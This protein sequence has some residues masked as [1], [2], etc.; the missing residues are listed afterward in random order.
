MNVKELIMGQPPEAIA[1]ILL[2]KLCAKPD[3]RERVLKRLLK[4]IEDLHQI[5]PV[6][7]GHLILGIV[8][9]DEDGDF[10]NPCLY[11]KEE[12]EPGY[13]ADSELAGLE[14]IEGL[15]EEEIEWLA[16]IRDFPASYA[17]EFSPW[18]EILGY[19]IDACN[20][21][22]VGKAELCAAVIWEMTF[23]GFD[24]ERVEEERQKLYEATREAEEISKL[25]KEEREKHYVS[26]EELFS[27]FGLPER[28]EEEKQEAHRNL[29]REVLTNNLRTYRALK[30][31]MSGILV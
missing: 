3:D 10:L 14:D 12:L 17:F 1:A 15:S 19:E 30:K 7:S 8:H 20:A 6:D 13:R 18:N 28:T 16:H 24:E 26:A 31:Y 29:C 11:C 23:F 25:P 27:K 22:D 4:F 9:V 21:S 5:E 2:D